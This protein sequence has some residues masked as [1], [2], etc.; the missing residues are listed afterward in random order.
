[1]PT[2]NVLPDGSPLI[3]V[4]LGAE[5][6]SVALIEPYVTTAEH[7]PVVVFAMTFAGHV[8][9]GA[10]MSDLV[11]LQIVHPMAVPNALR[12]LICQ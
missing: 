1:M 4:I 2:G 3:R 11:K 5:Q 12:G 8:I 9:V 7:M 10:I 6:L